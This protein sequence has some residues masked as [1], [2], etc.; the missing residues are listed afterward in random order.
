MIFF[1]YYFT[2][3]V[4]KSQFGSKIFMSLLFVQCVFPCS[5]FEENIFISEK[6]IASINTQ[7]F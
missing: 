5:E 2:D 1:F 4:K 6:I 7:A 3:K